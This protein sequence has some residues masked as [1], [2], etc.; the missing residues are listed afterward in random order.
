M[1]ASPHFLRDSTGM[2]DDQL[3]EA[4]DLV[5]VRGL[6]TGGVAATGSWVSRG[7]LD[8]PLKFFA[9]VCGRTRLTTD[10]IDRPIELEPGDVAILN[11]RSWLQ[12]EGGTG[13]QPACQSRRAARRADREPDGL[14]VR[15]P[16]VR[17]APDAR[18][19]ARLRRPGRASPRMASPADRRTAAPDAQPHACRPRKA[20]GPA[21]TGACRGDVAILV[22]RT[23]PDGGRR[24]TAHL[25]QPL[26]DAP[27]AARAS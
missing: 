22:R 17:A 5:E 18:G 21:G 19:A 8:D 9:M 20:V 16:A 26:A 7:T 12:L 6:L 4:F 25:P 1:V 10:G 14:S 27:G 2:V 15:D 3:S 24:A 23:L 13:D 11:Q